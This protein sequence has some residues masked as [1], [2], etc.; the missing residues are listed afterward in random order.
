LNVWKKF[1]EEQPRW[2]LASKANRFVKGCSCLAQQLLVRLRGDLI[3]TF[4]ILTGREKLNKNDFFQLADQQ[5]GLQGHTLKAVQKEMSH[6]HKGK[7][8]QYASRG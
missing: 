2:F 3:E 5:H 1:R 7:Q 6:Y 8:F 4:K